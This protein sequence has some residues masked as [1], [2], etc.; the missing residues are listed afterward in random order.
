LIGSSGS[1]DLGSLPAAQQNPSQCVPPPVR[2]QPRLRSGRC[3][4]RDRKLHRLGHGGTN[5]GG[6][7][8]PS[9]PRIQAAY[10]VAMA[11][12]GSP[13][14]FLRRP[15]RYRRGRARRWTHHPDNPG[16]LPARDWLANLDLVPHPETELP[17]T[18]ALS[19]CAGKAPGFV[20][21]SS[22]APRAHHRRQR[23]LDTGQSAVVQD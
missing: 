5:W 7:I 23:Q 17:R 6:H 19:R 1:F 2:E 14:D 16:E 9:D 18:G 3:L 20:D 22:A 15:L 8:D 12:D 21:H 10:A 4:S 11:V 13:H